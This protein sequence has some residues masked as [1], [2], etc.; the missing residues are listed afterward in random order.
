MGKT[1]FFKDYS[2][3]K[4]EKED[5]FNVL[6][7]T[8]GFDKNKMIEMNRALV[9]AMLLAEECKGMFSAEKTST[10]IKFFVEVDF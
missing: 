2:D 10:G 3:Y 9:K 6:A 7:L 1:G 8:D 5:I 4:V